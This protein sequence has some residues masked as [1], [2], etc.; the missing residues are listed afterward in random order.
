FSYGTAY[1]DSTP[2]APV[3]FAA[4]AMAYNYVGAAD[5]GYVDTTTGTVT[6]KVAVSRINALLPPGHPPIAQGSWLSGLR[7]AA[8]ATGRGPRDNTRGGTH[9]FYVSFN[10]P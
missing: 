8:G 4:Y 7:G 2:L 9:N 5:S 6:V 3:V 10:G 1:R